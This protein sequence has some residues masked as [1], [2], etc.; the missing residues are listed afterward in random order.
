MASRRVTSKKAAPKSKAWQPPA[1]LRIEVSCYRGELGFKSEATV[2][3]APNVALLLVAMMREVVK[4]APDVL[5]YAD[6]VPGTVIAYDWA[7]EYEGNADARPTI[8]FSRV[9]PTR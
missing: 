4:H 1:G 5:P 9:R 3:D 2:A 6:S 8:G 7:E